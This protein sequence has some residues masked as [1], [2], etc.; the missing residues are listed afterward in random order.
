[1]SGEATPEQALVR[2]AAAWR[3]ITAQLGLEKQRDAYQ[4]S[5]EYLP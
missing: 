1:V 4:H 3:R 2:A 5:V